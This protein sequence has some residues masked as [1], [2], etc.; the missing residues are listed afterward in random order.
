MKID[1]TS[2]LSLHPVPSEA[3]IYRK[4]VRAVALSCVGLGGTTNKKDPRRFMME[5][6]LGKPP[7]GGFW[8]LDRPFKC[9][10]DANGN[11]K[12]QGV[13]TCGLVANG[14]WRRLG[15]AA[16]WLY[17]PYINGSAITAARQFGIDN[18]AWNRC[19]NVDTRPNIGD[20]SVM[21][22]G[23][24]THVATC[25]G[26]RE[27][28]DGNLY[29]QS[30]EGGQVDKVTGLQCVELKERLWTTRANLVFAGNKSM[31][32]WISVIL[33]PNDSEYVLA[34]DG[35]EEAS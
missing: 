26:W 22:A 12:T 2:R 5:G 17:N 18:D 28:Q 27:D 31:V 32:G 7:V 34:P 24:G 10:Q 11:W 15:I 4:M 3:G 19:Y 23:I 13:S 9:W 25:V 14:I 6:L 33:L 21:G 8:D 35:W 20:Y 29:M 1:Y 16:K 30:V